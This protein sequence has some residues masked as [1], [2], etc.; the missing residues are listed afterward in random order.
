MSKRHVWET[1]LRY[2]ARLKGEMKTAD[3]DLLYAYYVGLL[4]DAERLN[5]VSPVVIAHVLL[6]IG[7]ILNGLGLWLDSFIFEL[8]ERRHVCRLHTQHDSLASRMN[9]SSNSYFI[10]HSWA[11]TNLPE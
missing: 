2:I 11:S 3:D 7:L 6:V 4:A 10:R 8:F 9:A 1:K 5:T